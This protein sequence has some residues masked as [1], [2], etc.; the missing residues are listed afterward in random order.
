VTDTAVTT[1]VHIV[2]VH[3]SVAVH[4]DT[5]ITVVST[6]VVTAAGTVVMARTA[7]IVVRLNL[8]VVTVT[9]PVIRMG[10]SVVC[11]V[12]SGTERKP[13]YKVTVTVR[14]LAAIHISSA[15]IPHPGPRTSITGSVVTTRY[16]YT[17]AR[18]RAGIS[19]VNVVI[20]QTTAFS[21]I[22]LVGLPRT[23]YMSAGG[24]DARMTYLA[25]VSRA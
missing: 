5:V 18:T 21:V 4:L 23:V 15:R 12:G 9:V 3:R 16:A 10:H 22:H 17:A 19:R 24:N 1:P 8:V 6:P 25:T 13:V 14:A 20:E 2:I 7:N 11:R